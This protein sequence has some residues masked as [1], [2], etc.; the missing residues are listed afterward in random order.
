[1]KFV[2][3]KNVIAQ[4][5]LEIVHESHYR[6]PGEHL[7]LFD[8]G[9]DA[10]QWPPQ[11]NGNETFSTKAMST[12]SEVQRKHKRHHASLRCCATLKVSQFDSI[13]WHIMLNLIVVFDFNTSRAH[14]DSDQITRLWSNEI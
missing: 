9:G 1:M 2:I 5:A 8:S 12:R 7:R 14:N 11:T 6:H 4:T 13:S 3:E 10:S